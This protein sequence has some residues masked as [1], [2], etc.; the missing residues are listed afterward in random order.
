MEKFYCGEMGGENLKWNFD[1]LVGVF[2]FNYR[3]WF[4]LEFK[5]YY[6][7]FVFV[8]MFLLH[9]SIQL[10]KKLFAHETYLLTKI[11]QS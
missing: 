5:L 8:Y 10:Y 9:S 6:L 7:S 3:T 1:G 2:S 4:M 11:K